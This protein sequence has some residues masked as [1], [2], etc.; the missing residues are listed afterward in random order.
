MNSFRVLLGQG[1]TGKGK[2]KAGPGPLVPHSD[3]Y[4]P[5][6]RDLGLLPRPELTGPR[7]VL[8]E[9]GRA[10]AASLRLISTW[11]FRPP[12]PALTSLQA[13]VCSGARGTEG[14]QDFPCR[15]FGLGPLRNSEPLVCWW[16]N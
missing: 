12:I 13:W 7:A 9:A 15:A 8:K 16:G 14:M 4:S 1:M 3:L 6:T 11:G 2:A 5:W 10:V